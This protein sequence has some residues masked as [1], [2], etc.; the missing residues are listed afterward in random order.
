M[1]KYVHRPDLHK[2]VYA[3]ADPN[4]SFVSSY[5]L[6]NLLRLQLQISRQRGNITLNNS[7]Q[8]LDLRQNQIF[9][10]KSEWEKHLNRFCERAKSIYQ[11]LGAWAASHFILQTISL[12]RNG[13]NAAN[14]SFLGPKDAVKQSLLRVLN[15]EDFTQGRES[16]SIQ[17][18]D[19]LSSKVNKLIKFITQ[20]KPEECSGLIFVRQRVTVSLLFEIL[21]THPKTAKQFQCATFVGLSNSSKKRY[22]LHELLDVGSQKTNLD[23]FR[24]G[25]KN[26]IIATDALEEGIDVAA[27]NLVICFDLPPNLKSFIQRRGR[28]RMEKS[29]FGMMLP[30][31]GNNSKI[32]I[33]QDLESEMIKLYQDDERARREAASIENKDEQLHYKIHIETTG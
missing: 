16:L 10:P 28:A 21:S 23:E 22:A 20:Q 25:K 19:A 33:W 13:N 15:R 14:P 4:E 29:Q 6:H 8:Q 2:I 26:I 18:R 32:D 11:E 5:P 30:Q 31:D 1:L 3:S 27:C 24:A 7:P 12:L 17:T 9:N